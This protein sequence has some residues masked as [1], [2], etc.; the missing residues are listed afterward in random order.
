MFPWPPAEYYQ[1]V[2]DHGDIYQ[3][4]AS[5]YGA[6]PQL[7]H[8]S[9]FNQEQEVFRVCRFLGAITAAFLS[10]LLGSGWHAPWP[11]ALR[12]LYG[13]GKT[14]RQVGI[15]CGL[16]FSPTLEGNVTLHTMLYAFR[17]WMLDGN[18]NVVFNKNVFAAGALKYIQA[19]YRETGTP[20]QLTWGSGGNVRPCWRVRLPPPPMPSAYC[21]QRKSRN[22][23]WPE[24]SGSSRLCSA[25]GMGVTALPHVTNCSVVWKF[26]QIRMEPD[27]SW[28]I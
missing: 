27:S 28:L 16:A 20:E 2:I 15:P 19:L 21:A 13:G 10:G 3:M 25:N 22:R 6:I 24:S 9:T 26:A 11:G 17:A 8:R 4:V 23:S 18:G 14:A 1:H 5:K 12:Y 7:A